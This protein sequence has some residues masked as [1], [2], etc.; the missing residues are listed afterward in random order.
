MALIDA[1]LALEH[2][3]ADVESFLPLDADPAELA[4]LLDAWAPP[5]RRSNTSRSRE[6]QLVDWIAWIRDCG[7]RWEA[8]PPAPHPTGE[9][10]GGLIVRWAQLAH[11]P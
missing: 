3:A 1:L 5:R 10:M 8:R 6:L 2:A 7:E 4:E 11:T 9:E